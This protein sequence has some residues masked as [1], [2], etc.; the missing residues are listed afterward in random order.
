M[1]TCTRW[2]NTS[3]TDFSPEPVP[4]S[5]FPVSHVRQNN[6]G[7]IC[8]YV[9]SRVPSFEAIYTTLLS[10]LRQF[11][12]HVNPNLRSAEVSS[13]LAGL[14]SPLSVC[15]C[16]WDMAESEEKPFDRKSGGRC[17][18]HA[19]VFANYACKCGKDVAIRY[20]YA[21]ISHVVQRR[22]RMHTSPVLVCL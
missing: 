16:H 7:S 22:S 2:V 15:G 11:G 3:G 21:L 9:S 19:R 18:H 6:W 17:M 1:H 13:S 14:R 8:G 20:R 4:Q 5:S 12:P 10:A